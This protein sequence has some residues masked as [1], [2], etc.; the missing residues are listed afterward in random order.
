MG[1]DAAF[2]PPPHDGVFAANVIGASAL[3]LSEFLLVA[4]NTFVWLHF[5]GEEFLGISFLILSIP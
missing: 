2:V 4:F 3:E 5:F 1:E